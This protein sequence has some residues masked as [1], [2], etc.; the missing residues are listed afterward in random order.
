MNTRLMV[1]IQPKEVREA[2]QQMYH[3]K[4]P[5]LDGISLVFYQ[6]YWDVIGKDVTDAVLTTPN[7]GNLPSSLN[8]T[9]IT[10]ISKKKDPKK[11]FDY[12]PISLCNVLYKIIAK[13]LANCLKIV[14]PYVISK[15]Q[16][17]FVLNKLITDNVLVAFELMHHLQWKRRGASF[18]MEKER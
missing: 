3:I 7:M 9:F 6:Q 5:D 2:I 4:A 12:R 14:L 10:L 17:A 1:G 15:T 8:H 16:N 18:T 11:D 13:V